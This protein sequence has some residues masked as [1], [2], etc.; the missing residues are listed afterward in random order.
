MLMNNWFQSTYLQLIKIQLVFFEYFYDLSKFYR[1]RIIH[2]T[3]FC[4]G[5][6]ALFTQKVK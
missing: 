2:T 6:N 1:I 5:S 4:Y 3:L